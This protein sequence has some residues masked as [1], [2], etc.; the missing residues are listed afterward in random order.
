MGRVDSDRRDGRQRGGL[1]TKKIYRCLDTEIT[2]SQLTDRH[3]HQAYGLDGGLPGAAGMTWYRA[4][5]DA[6]SGAPW[7]TMVDAFA[8]RSTSKWSNVTFKPGDQV[9]ILTP[10]GGGFGDPA[11]RPPADLEAD[12]KDAFVSPEAAR[13]DYGWTGDAQ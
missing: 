9:Q 7:Q 6:D 11:E 8:K 12:V 3:Q 2:A 13:R 1:G 5:S 4:G 10:G